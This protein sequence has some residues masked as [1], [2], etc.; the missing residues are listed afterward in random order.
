MQSQLG[1]LNVDLQICVLCIDPYACAVIKCFLDWS[2]VGFPVFNLIGVVMHKKILGG[3]YGIFFY[4]GSTSMFHRRS[5]ITV[6]STSSLIKIET[7][8]AAKTIMQYRQ[9]SS[10][11]FLASRVVFVNKKKISPLCRLW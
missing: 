1:L 4:V 2:Q 9:H 5:V 7:D 3:R 10:P 8:Q 11:R 6:T